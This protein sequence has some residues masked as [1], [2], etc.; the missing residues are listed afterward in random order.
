MAI[1]TPGTDTEAAFEDLGTR[2]HLLYT[3]AADIPVE[4][5]TA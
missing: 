2:V 5:R 4:W 3:E 1:D